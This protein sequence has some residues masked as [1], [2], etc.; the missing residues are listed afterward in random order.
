[1]NI[2]HFRS[3]GSAEIHMSSWRASLSIG[4]HRHCRPHHRLGE[5]N[6]IH[7]HPLLV[8]RPRPSD[9]IVNLEK[10]NSIHP[11]TGQTVGPPLRQGLSASARLA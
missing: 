5:C 7:T 9:Q 2:A 1:M 6:S 4:F 11:Q 10:D 3:S 8:S